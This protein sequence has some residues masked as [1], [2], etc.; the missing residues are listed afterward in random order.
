M[1]TRLLELDSVVSGQRI[2]K[3][4]PPTSGSLHCQSP[5]NEIGNTWYPPF[6]SDILQPRCYGKQLLIARKI[7]D[8]SE[9]GLGVELTG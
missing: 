1:I 6:S 2:Q 8:Q 4:A 5:G 3:H 7:K 9:I